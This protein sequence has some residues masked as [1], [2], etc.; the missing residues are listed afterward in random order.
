M[1]SKHEE[2]AFVISEWESEGGAPNR[3]E[4]LGQYRRRFDG[5]GT[6]SIYQD[7]QSPPPVKKHPQRFLMGGAALRRCPNIPSPEAQLCPGSL[8]DAHSPRRSRYRRLRC[9]ALP[10]L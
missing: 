10:E 7:R 3:S 2:H 8:L 6:Y 9:Q 1:K 5:D 4:Q